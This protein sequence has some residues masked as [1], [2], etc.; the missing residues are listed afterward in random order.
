MDDNLFYLRN[1]TT[2]KIHI[3]GVNV[4]PDENGNSSL[5]EEINKTLDE[6][7]EQGATS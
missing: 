5:E 2:G 4:N 7:L 6:N 1:L 3:E